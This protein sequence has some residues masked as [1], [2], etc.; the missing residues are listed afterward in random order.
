MAPEQA[1]REL[2]EIARAHHVHF[3]VE[4]EVV[5]PSPYRSA[6][7]KTRT[8]A[9]L[10]NSLERTSARQKS[11]MPAKMVALAAPLKAMTSG[12]CWMIRSRRSAADPSCPTA[13][14]ADQPL[15]GAQP[16]VDGG[17]AALVVRPDRAIDKTLV[18][19]TTVSHG[20]DRSA[21]R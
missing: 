19:V 15:P 4:P 9:L 16:R 7:E 10:E 17:E 5:G 8:P 12:A 6:P 13:E 20:G 11:T 18:M 2:L 21:A 1:E 14:K 3:D